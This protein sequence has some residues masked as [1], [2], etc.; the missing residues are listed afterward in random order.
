[1]VDR[2]EYEYSDIVIPDATPAS[3]FT[4]ASVLARVK[5]EPGYGKRRPGPAGPKMDDATLESLARELKEN[6][7]ARP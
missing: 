5:S 7:T 2:F 6:G 3:A 4:R 1:M